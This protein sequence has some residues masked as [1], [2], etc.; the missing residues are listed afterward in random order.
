MKTIEDDEF[1]EIGKETTYKVPDGF[2]ENISEKT[3][4]KAKEREQNREKIRVLWRTVAV[5][6][7]MAAMVLLGYFIFEPD[8]KPAT[9]LIVQNKQPVEQPVIHE[10]EISKQP[11]VA[12]VKK[13][14][15]EKTNLKE[16][17]TEV[18][19]DVLTDLSDEELL[20]LAAMI[21]TDP[22]IS[23]SAQ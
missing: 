19:S 20:Q 16:N 22:F 13:T 11:E 8:N 9:N 3:L 14:E 21:K 17:S 2:F 1:Q 6:A 4:L 15:P 5:T 10:Q 23:E 18:L 12:E 7:T